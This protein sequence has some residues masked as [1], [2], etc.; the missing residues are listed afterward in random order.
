MANQQNAANDSWVAYQ[1]RKSQ[2]F[3]KQDEARRSDAEAGARRRA[4]RS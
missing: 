4:R 3:Q 2:E 1:R